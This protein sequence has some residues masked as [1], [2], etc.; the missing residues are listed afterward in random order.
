LTWVAGYMLTCILL[1]VDL[2]PQSANKV[3]MTVIQYHHLPPKE[4]IGYIT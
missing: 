4:N 2:N 3:E 1:S